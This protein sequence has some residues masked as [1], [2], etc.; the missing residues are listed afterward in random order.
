MIYNNIQSNTN[1]E[2]TAKFNII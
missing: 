2:Q 1:N